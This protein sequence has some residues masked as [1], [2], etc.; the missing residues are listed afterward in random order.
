[1]R[2]LAVL[3]FVGMLSGCGDDNP[4]NTGDMAVKPDLG[5]DM[6]VVVP[7]GGD[8]MANTDCRAGASPTCLKARGQTSGFCSA[9]CQDDTDCGD[10]GTC[11]FTPQTSGRCARACETAA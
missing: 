4:T 10:N 7:I 11:V 9:T 5:P 3:G 8:C 1:M 6:T 2:W